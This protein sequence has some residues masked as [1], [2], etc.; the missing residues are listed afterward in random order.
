[1]NILT[2]LQK[3]AGSLKRRASGGMSAG[4]VAALAVCATT[5]AQAQVTVSTLGGGP[6]SQDISGVGNSIIT[7]TGGTGGGAGIK[8]DNPLGMAFDGSG[9]LYIAENGQGNILKVTNPGNRAT[10]FTY[11]FIA[12]LTDPIALAFASN[13]DLFVLTSVDGSIRRYTADG[14]FVSLV[15]SAL[16]APSAMTVLSNDNLI[17]TEIGGSVKQVTPAGVVTLLNNTFVN[18]TGISLYGSNKV[19][20]ADGGDNSIKLLNLLTPGTVTVLAGG[21]G[22]G[23]TNGLALNAKFNM[24]RYLSTA[25]DGSLIVADQ[26]NQRVR[27]LTSD[28][29]VSTIYGVSTNQWPDNPFYPTYPGWKDGTNAHANQPFGVIVGPGATNIFV[30]EIGHT[31]DLLRVASGFNLG[32]STGTNNTTT[33]V[34][35]DTTLTNNLI[36]LGF[37]NGE[38]SS[39][40]IGSPGQYFQVPITLT[41]PTSTK[42]HS[43]GFAVAVTNIEGTVLSA[44]TE[45]GFESKLVSPFTAPSGGTVYGTIPNLAF[46]GYSTNIVQNPQTGEFTTNYIGIYTNVLITNLTARM[47]DVAWLEVEGQG[48]LYPKEQDLIQYSMAYINIFGAHQLGRVIVGSFGFRIPPT[49]PIGSEYRVQVFNASA[50]TGF[51][52]AVDLLAPTNANALLSGSANSIKRILVQAPRTYLVGDLEGFRWYNVG[53][54]GNGKLDMI[55]VQEAFMMA[56]FRYNIPR[57]TNSDFY[58]TVDSY[59]V[60]SGIDPYS[61]NINAVTTGDGNI[62]IDDVITTLRRTLDYTVQWVY[63]YGGGAYASNGPGATPPDFGLSSYHATEL[64][65]TSTGTT[66]SIKASDVVQGS[67]TI[68]VP[69][70][71]IVNGDGRP[72]RMLLSVLVQ[73]E[74]GAPELSE[75]VGYVPGSTASIGLPNSSFIIRRGNNALSLAW[76][77]TSGFG[78]VPGLPSGDNTL[79]TLAIKPSRALAT[80]EFYRIRVMS[81]SASPGYAYSFTTQ[82]GLVSPVSMDSVSTIG[83]GISDAWRY[84]YF[85]KVLDMMALKD[86]DS[87]GDGIPNWAEYLAGTNPTDGKSAFK[88]TRPDSDTSA[89]VKIRFQTVLGKQYVVESCVGFGN[90]WTQ[91]GG[92]INGTDGEVVVTDN[93]T[94]AGSKFYRIRL[95]NSTNPAQ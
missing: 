88:L 67:G 54:F 13:G 60:G 1:M 64:A 73:P 48:T 39:D 9:N 16:V 17:V 27:I 33:N 77:D 61:G 43:M 42:I 65:T 57:P 36:T 87:D 8:L 56:S 26:N 80:G 31:L 6:G 10:S 66:I 32:V 72:K 30:T 11:L 35:V 37:A 74:N 5:S 20:V 68:N 70:H 78:G 63:R 21:N 94:G 28:G 18:P 12:G 93:S 40:Y 85:G 4:I 47:L 41:L 2:S 29:A 49:A 71:A 79:V 44:P 84:R 51:N 34:F 91:V 86:A 58:N 38:G 82:D 59:N 14:A 55:D 95:L 22:A 62:D 15:T 23:F 45:I 90:P 75:A 25:P 3:L 83:D 24:P 46:I 69:I 52:H 76:I 92:T 53:E 50:A 81:Y 89:G 19:A 7:F